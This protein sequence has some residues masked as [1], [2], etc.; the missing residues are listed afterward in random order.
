MVKLIKQKPL[1]GAKRR[2]RIQ[3]KVIKRIK[4]VFPLATTPLNSKGKRLTKI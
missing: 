2:R 4:K 1:P 3:K